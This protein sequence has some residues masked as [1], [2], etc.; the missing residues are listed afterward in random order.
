MQGSDGLYCI[1][2]EQNSFLTSNIFALSKDIDECASGIHNCINGTANCINTIGSYKCACKSGY[3]GDGRSYCI[4]DGK[5]KKLKGKGK[6][7]LLFKCLVYLAM[8][9]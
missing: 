4:P 7:L 1:A 2:E 5:W 8:E 9:H 6:E 3:R